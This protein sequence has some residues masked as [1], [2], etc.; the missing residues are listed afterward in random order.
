MVVKISQNPSAV[1]RWP[2]EFDAQ[3]IL[4]VSVPIAC[5][6]SSCLTR[7]I[8]KMKMHC[9]NSKCHLYL[10]YF[11][12]ISLFLI[13]RVVA[14]REALGRLM[15]GRT[16]IA[17]AHRLATLR[18][19]DRVV[20][21]KAG[22]IIEDGSPDRLMQGRGPY[23]ELVPPLGPRGIPQVCTLR[24]LTVCGIN[25]LALNLFHQNFPLPHRAVAFDDFS[26][27][28]IS[29]VLSGVVTD[30]DSH[31]QVKRANCCGTGRL[32]RIAHG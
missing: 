28:S 3:Q 29:M 13:S 21:L 25:E 24:T 26:G 1:F 15:R 17:I 31:I 27:T 9:S 4:I 16:V 20:I 32:Q 6:D 2:P 22:K 18:D 11:C 12:A 8:A 10:P 7:D 19:F 30:A 14:I 5:I 23:R